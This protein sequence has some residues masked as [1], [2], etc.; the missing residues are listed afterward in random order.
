MPIVL[1]T[2]DDCPA[3]VNFKNANLERLKSEIKKNEL[4]LIHIDLARRSDLSMK[5]SKSRT[6]SG[7]EDIS[8]S[9]RVP[10]KLL[11]MVAYFP[12]LAQFDADG[13]VY[14]L[15]G[16]VQNGK[17]VYGPK[18]IKDVITTAMTNE[19]KKK[20]P[21]SA[22]KPKPSVQDTIDTSYQIPTAE[23]RVMTDGSVINTPNVIYRMYGGKTNRAVVDLT[24]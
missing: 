7:L 2:A 15:M 6:P 17:F 19:T 11:E 5:D 4:E 23:R 8:K 22:P 18:D 3:C 21:K 24:N 14:N 12:T 9:Y 10:M 16:T 13:K 20:K 1:V